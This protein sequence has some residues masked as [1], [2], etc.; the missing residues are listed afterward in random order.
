MKL[1]KETL[2]QIIKEEVQA[3]LN[4]EDKF[5]K[6]PSDAQMAQMRKDDQKFLRDVTRSE[7]ELYALMDKLSKAGHAK[8]KT[9]KQKKKAVKFSKAVQAFLD[10]IKQSADAVEKLPVDPK[11]PK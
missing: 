4:E 10:T 3:V 11:V 5:D 6:F 2:K 7:R 1:T 9:D 8:A